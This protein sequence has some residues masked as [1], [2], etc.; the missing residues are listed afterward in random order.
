M[1]QFWPASRLRSPSGWSITMGAVSRPDQRSYSDAERAE[2]VELIR[3]HG[4][5]EAARQ[6]GIPGGTLRRRR[7]ERGESGPP[8]GQ[9]ADDWAK[10]KEALAVES[11]AAAR[12]ALKQVKKL[13]AAGKMALSSSPGRSPAVSC[14]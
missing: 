6:T 11:F 5:A 12:S 8:S 1:C 13:I 7:M 2:A 3:E 4:A 9:D 10:R 14:E